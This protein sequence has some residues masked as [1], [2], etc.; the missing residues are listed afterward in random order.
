MGKFLIV[1]PKL[2]IYGG[3]ERVCH[4]IIKA[5]VTHGQQV[6]LLTFDF[7]ENK[8]SEIMG[9][10]LPNGITVHTLGKQCDVEANPP[11]S[12]YKCRQN[13]IRLLK[14]YKVTA[15]QYDYV[16]STQTFS[17][18]ETVLLDNSHKNIAYVH[19]PE[20]SYDYEQFKL[21]KRL[22][23]YVYKKLLE[24]HISKLNLIF[25]NSNY[26]KTMTQKYWQRF[27]IS[28]P[29]AIYPPVETQFWSDKP[30]DKRVNRVV[31][32]ARFIP[33]KRHEILKQLAKEFPQLNFVSIGLLRDT[34]Q[35]WFENFS[36]DLPINYTLKTNLPEEEL[37]TILQDS[38]IY[39][40]LME[41]E[42]FG[43]AP[44][45]ALASGC[46]TFVHNSGGSGEIVPPEFRWESF[47]DL[48]SKIAKLVDITN[49]YTTWIK[50]RDELREKILVLKPETFEAQ[51]WTH[52]ENLIQTNIKNP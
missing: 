40:H 44:M 32:V 41:G 50:Q 46:V 7:D 11:F 21:Y 10:K 33:Q 52:V 39:V 9:E 47:E 8:Y 48:K 49:L 31:Y 51:I 24:R 37:I 28:E 17:V 5:L 38:T 25:C 1:H 6:E 18:F 30:L 29:L 3:G 26:T 27:G 45:E 14:K 23:L 12:V 13:I 42:H 43:I 35:I 36:K 16:F 20:I 15:A 22:Y 4:H 2:D 19:F 34:E